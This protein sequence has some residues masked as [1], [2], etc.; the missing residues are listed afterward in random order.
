MFA[1]EKQV[2]Y[3]PD[4]SPDVRA[5]YALAVTAQLFS[6]S[7]SKIKNGAALVAYERNSI[8][9]LEDKVCAVAIGWDYSPFDVQDAWEFTPIEH[10]LFQLRTLNISATSH[11][12][13]VTAT[14]PPS[15]EECVSLIQSNVRHVEFTID[16]PHPKCPIDDWFSV[17]QTL[18]EYRNKRQYHCERTFFHHAYTYNKELATYVRG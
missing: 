13:Y 10:A 12:V 2:S 15:I 7:A 4:S 9:P 18:E 1:V 16:N 8:A 17:F 5:R 14:Y 6:T 11:R 3:F